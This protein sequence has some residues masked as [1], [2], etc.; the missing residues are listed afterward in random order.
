MIFYQ[1]GDLLD[2]IQLQI[3]MDF[4][5]SSMSFFYQYAFPIPLSLEEFSPKIPNQEL[6]KM[7]RKSRGYQKMRYT[8]IS[9]G[10]IWK[11]IIGGEQR[12]LLR[13]YRRF[14][15]E[16]LLDKVPLV[17]PSVILK[18]ITVEN[19]QKAAELLSNEI[20]NN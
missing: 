7:S 18:P 19:F 3:F 8:T 13:A 2:W 11:S 14:N 10:D 15:A 6:Y 1:V 16:D 17:C 12:L 5:S 9:L 4:C 20:H